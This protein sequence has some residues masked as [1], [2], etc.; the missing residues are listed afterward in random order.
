MTSGTQLRELKLSEV[1]ILSVAI[2]DPTVLNFHG[3]IANCFE[4]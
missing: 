2:V 3:R 4:N 1:F